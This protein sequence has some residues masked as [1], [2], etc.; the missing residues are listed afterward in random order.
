MRAGAAAL[1][2]SSV[3]LLAACAGG[4][5]GGGA[6][7]SATPGT[8]APGTSA[9]GSTPATTPAPGTGETSPAPTSPA[10]GSSADAPDTDVTVDIMPDGTDV[11]TSYRVVCSGGLP[12]DG[13]DHPTAEDACSFLAQ[14]GL[15]VFLRLPN[16]DQMCTQMILGPQTARA[17]G[18]IDGQNV[19]KTFSLT[20]GCKISEW[21]SAEA[22]LGRAASAGAQ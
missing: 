4:G 13:T 9:P 21:E 12:A 18:K 22:L 6:T 8:S 16:Q 5:P 20:D 10:P 15:I 19:D 17:Y 3:L 14:S 11:G 1:M 7:T 2:L